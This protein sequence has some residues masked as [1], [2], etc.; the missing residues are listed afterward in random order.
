MQV[1]TNPDS[2]KDPSVYVCTS[3]ANLREQEPP[4]AGNAARATY[5][6]AIVIGQTSPFDGTSAIYV[7]NA[8]SGAADDG[9]ATIKPNSPQVGGQ[10]GR[11]IRTSVIGSG[12][13]QV[14]AGNYGGANPGTVGVVATVI[15]SIATDLDGQMP[16]YVWNGAA[17]I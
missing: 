9:A 5:T 6:L 15:G 16:Q 17:W 11:W 7:W 13:V 10:P 8:S 4:T 1:R 3:I 12:S 14:F 2:F